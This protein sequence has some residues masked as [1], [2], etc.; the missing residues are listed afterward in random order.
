MAVPDAAFSVHVVRVLRELDEG[1]Q[2]VD[3]RDAGYRLI[4]AEEADLTRVKGRW[5][6]QGLGSSPRRIASTSLG[7]FFSLIRVIE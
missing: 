1:G 4:I 7:G 3:K 2:A 5:R 6:A